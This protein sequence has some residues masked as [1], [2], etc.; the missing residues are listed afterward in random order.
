MW[1]YFV[2]SSQSCAILV[3]S[4]FG[5]AG[6]IS[7]FGVNLFSFTPFLVLFFLS[8]LSSLSSSIPQPQSNLLQ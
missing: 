8:F 2:C 1:N 6:S 7:H 4:V 5:F 3:L